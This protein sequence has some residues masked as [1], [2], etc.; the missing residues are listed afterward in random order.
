MKDVGRNNN[1]PAKHVRNSISGRTIAVPARVSFLGHAVVAMPNED[2]AIIIDNEDDKDGDV[3]S[4]LPPPS[5]S[6]AAP[7]PKA[8]AAV[9]IKQPLTDNPLATK[10]L[11][12]SLLSVLRGGA[13]K[14]PMASSE[15][16]AT[17]ACTKTAVEAKR[18]YHFRTFTM[19]LEEDI[20]NVRFHKG[21]PESVAHVPLN[22]V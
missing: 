6:P 12:R 13:A 3:Q 20:R 8:G 4:G 14:Q 17:K 7:W 9:A 2:I 22:R 5:S 21:V 19:D 16:I 10:K 15:M 18:R 1:I 11:E